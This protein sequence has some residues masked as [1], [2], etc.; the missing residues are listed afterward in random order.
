MWGWDIMQIRGKNTKNVSETM[1]ENQREEERWTEREWEGLSEKK[2][3]SNCIVVYW[4]IR[5]RA[6]KWQLFT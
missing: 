5:G 2:P 1:S 3:L 4:L 6:P